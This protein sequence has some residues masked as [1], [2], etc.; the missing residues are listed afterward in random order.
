MP[1][2]G[3]PRS[4]L[5]YDT[6]NDAIRGILGRYARARFIRRLKQFGE[7]VS[8]DSVHLEDGSGRRGGVS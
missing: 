3:R 5:I 7:D 1:S 4:F 8:G 2:L 6:R